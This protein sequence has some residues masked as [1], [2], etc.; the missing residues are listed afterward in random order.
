MKYLNLST[1]ETDTFDPSLSS[2]EYVYSQSQKGGFL[3]WIL[4]DSKNIVFTAL[5]KNRPDVAL[6]LMENGQELDLS[7]VNNDNGMT[8]LHYLVI[9]GSQDSNL[10]Q[11]VLD[12]IANND[13]SEVV[14]ATDKK[15][16][17]PLH[18]AVEVGNNVMATA[19]IAKGAQK[20]VE[21]N[22]GFAVA[23]ESQA[24]N[25]AVVPVVV[26]EKDPSV[27]V[28]KECKQPDRD[29]EHVVPATTDDGLQQRLA[30]VIA[31]FKNRTVTTDSMGPLNLD[32]AT[33]TAPAQM[34]AGSGIYNKWNTKTDSMVLDSEAFI[35]TLLNK[36]NNQSMRGGTKTSVI[37]H[38]KLNTYSEM[39]LGGG[40]SDEFDEFSDDEGDSDTA[41]LAR[42]IKNQTEEIRERVLKR[43]QD[44]MSVD[45]EVARNYRAA[46]YKMIRE[47]HPELNNVDR[48]VEMEKMVS[49]N[50]ALTILKNIDIEKVTREIKEH[51]EQKSSSS[52]EEKPKKAPRAKKEEPSGEEKPKRARKGKKDETL[53]M[54]TEGVSSTSSL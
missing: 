9:Y 18:Y 45:A 46:L 19:L 33:A 17:T 39:S 52:T 48:H 25:P 20:N 53:S 22:E 26:L 30:N 15:G 3:D 10:G 12:I 5:V 34:T 11:R 4:G 54:S 49:S 32:T 23:T 41:R 38:R 7:M 44:L 42:S 6:F 1:K 28:Q 29:I 37:G 35:R 16:N 31:D 21:N 2:T 51:I 43:I 40:S 27:F 24:L 13:I 50:E 47:N 36:F 8:S 14:N